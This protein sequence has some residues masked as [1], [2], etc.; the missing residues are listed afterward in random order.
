MVKKSNRSK[1]DLE[2]IGN[3]KQ[4]SPLKHWAFTLNNWTEEEFSSIVQ[5]FEQNGDKYVIGKEVGEKCGTPHLQG[6]VALKKKQRMTA[7][8]KINRRIRWSPARNIKASINYCTEDGD[9]T[10]NMRL[11]RKIVFP[12]MDKPWEKYILENI[13]EKLPDDRTIYWFWESKGNV[14]KTTFVKYLKVHHHAIELPEKRADAF[15][16]IAKIVEAGDTAIDLCIYDIP[17]SSMGYINYS[18]IEKVKN[19]CFSSGKYE[20]CDVCIACP[21]VIVF[22]N[23]EPQYEQ[24][25]MDRWKV[26]NLSMFDPQIPP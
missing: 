9:V 17:R 6:H 2:K 13:V 21:H 10:T 18:A 3:T 16:A 19:G 12:P 5:H 1:K 14:G 23:E 11:P 20:G 7:L 8:K 15:H 4:S 26:V 24:M 25:S 22:A